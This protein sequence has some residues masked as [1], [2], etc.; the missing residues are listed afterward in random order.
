[1]STL[2]SSDHPSCAS[3][4]RNAERGGPV[5]GSSAAY[6]HLASVQLRL[7]AFL[8]RSMTPLASGGR[9]ASEPMSDC[10]P[11][12]TH[13]GRPTGRAESRNAAIRCCEPI[14]TRQ[15]TCCSPVS[16]SG[17]HS[18]LGAFGLRSEAGCAKPRLPWLE[19]LLSFC[20]GCGS[21]AANSSGHQRRLLISLHSRTTEFRRAA[22]ANVPA[23]TLALVRS[24]LALRCSRAKR[25]SHIDPP[26]SSYAIMRRARPYRG[27]NPVPG[28]DVRGELDP[29]PGIREQPRPQSARWKRGSRV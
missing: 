17:R 2:R 26:A 21:K 15:P 28:K 22:E 10:R 23:G 1:M 13:P 14:S 8:R 6:C 25:A 12:D 18:K 27:E 16:Q 19:S 4:W 24:L 20:T 7:F 9:E 3:V 11:D 29:T 5:A